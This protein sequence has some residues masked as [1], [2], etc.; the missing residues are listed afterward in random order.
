MSLNPGIFLKKYVLGI[1]F[2]I[3]F[4]WDLAANEGPS[5]QLEQ[6]VVKELPWLKSSPVEERP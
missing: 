3:A 1:L 2:A 6:L 5:I 4:Q